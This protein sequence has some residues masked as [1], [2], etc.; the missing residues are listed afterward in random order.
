MGNGS[1]SRSAGTATGVYG[2]APLLAAQFEDRLP[3]TNRTS[4]MEAE[5]NE[6]A[7]AGF[8]LSSMMGGETAFGGNETVVVMSRDAEAPERRFEYR[9]LA[10]SRTSTMESEP[11][12]AGAQGFRYAGQTIF[13]T[14]FGGDEVV[15]ILERDLDQPEAVY[16]YRVLATRRTSTMESE[17]MDSGQVGFEL[18][19]MT[20]GETRFGGREVV[21]I[22]ARQCAAW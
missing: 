2:P 3:A 18:M 4:T 1:L 22:L 10:T 19:G 12:V 17:L 6:S 11:N 13:E 16:E 21:A 20:T 7:E 8:R 14:A 15:V 9:L 5:M